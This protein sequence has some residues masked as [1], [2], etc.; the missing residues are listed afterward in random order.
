VTGLSLLSESCLFGTQ[1]HGQ[2]VSV[3][4]KRCLAQQVS[5]ADADTQKAWKEIEANGEILAITSGGVRTRTRRIETT[6]KVGRDETA[7]PFLLGFAETEKMWEEVD[8]DANTFRPHVTMRVATTR[9]PFLDD[10]DSEDPEL[11]LNV[12]EAAQRAFP[13]S[14]VSVV[15]PS[16][17]TTSSSTT[18]APVARVVNWGQVLS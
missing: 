11:D 12:F 14:A 1:V 7:K 18:K 17:V 2:D 15:G 4:L 13:R 6:S 16:T 5:V 10:G 8:A 3:A 9:S